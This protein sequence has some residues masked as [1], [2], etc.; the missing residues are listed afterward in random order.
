MRDVGEVMRM[1]DIK[2]LIYVAKL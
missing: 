2:S 1:T